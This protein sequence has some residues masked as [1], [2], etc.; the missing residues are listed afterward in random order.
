MHLVAFIH[1]QTFHQNNSNYARTNGRT[2]RACVVGGQKQQTSINIY[3][4]TDL[5]EKILLQTSSNI[6]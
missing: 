5:Y 1:G 4:K 6:K 3:L 2:I